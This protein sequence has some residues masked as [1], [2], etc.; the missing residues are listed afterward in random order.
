MFEI[1]VGVDGSDRS[2][3]ALRWALDDARRRGDTSVLVVHAYRPEEVHRG[4]GTSYLTASGLA[5]TTA[6]EREERQ[7]R[8]AEALRAGE[9]V[10]DRALE[11]VGADAEGVTVKRL[12]VARE[13]SR[14]LLDLSRSTDLLVVG[15][16]GRGGFTGLLLGSVSQR[17]VQHASCPVAVIR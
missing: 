9:T 10:I 12:V 11:A 16:R 1:T 14:A 17:V 5:T 13:P 4:Y 2:N 3:E 7:T 8:D 15:S 6:T